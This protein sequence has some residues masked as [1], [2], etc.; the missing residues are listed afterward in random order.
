MRS[1][2]D[3]IIAARNMDSYSFIGL[4]TESCT[5]VGSLANDRLQLASTY[6]EGLSAIYEYILYSHRSKEHRLSLMPRILI[7]ILTSYF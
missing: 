2:I 1:N 4:F 7:N 3:L 5:Q 6:S